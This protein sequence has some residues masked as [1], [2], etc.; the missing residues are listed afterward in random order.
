MTATILCDVSNDISIIA[1]K[2]KIIIQ[3]EIYL[4]TQEI[5][6]TRTKRSS[7]SDQHRGSTSENALIQKTISKT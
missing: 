6:N 4:K 7:S 2:Q 1:T 3:T 5:N